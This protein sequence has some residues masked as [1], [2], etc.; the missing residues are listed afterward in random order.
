M[1]RI[2]RFRGQYAFL[3]N[4]YP[5]KITFNGLTFKNAEAAYQAHKTRDKEKRS[6]FTN[7]DPREA[8]RKGR[9]LKLRKDWNRIKVKVMYRIVKR[10]FTQNAYLKRKLLNTGNAILIE[11]NTWKDR[12]WGQYNGEGKNML[13]KILMKVRKELKQQ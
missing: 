2:T 13:G 7:L 5:A 10:K 3:S 9:T 1:K 12:F 4:F 6:S 11:G 8:K